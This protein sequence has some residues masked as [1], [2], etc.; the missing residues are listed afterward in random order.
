VPYS[1]FDYFEA[2]GKKQEIKPSANKSS[3][4]RPASLNALPS[5][6]QDVIFN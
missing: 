2:K 3:E 5:L 6:L 4:H 1:N